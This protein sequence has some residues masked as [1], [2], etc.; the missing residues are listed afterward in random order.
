M[1]ARQYLTKIS[2][3]AIIK[4]Y[5]EWITQNSS[6]ELKGVPIL[7]PKEKSFGDYSIGIAMQIA[8]ERK[9]NPEQ[10]AEDLKEALS[11]DDEFFDYFDLAQVVA[12]GFINFYLSKQYL[13]KIGQEVLRRGSHFGDLNIGEKQ[14]IQVEFVSANPTGP[15]TIGNGRGGPYGDVLAKI[16]QKAGYQVRK[17]YYIN[18]YGNQILALGHSVLKDNEAKYTGEYIDKLHQEL[19]YY[20]GDAYKIGK[21][22]AKIILEKSIKPTLKKLNI[23]FDE[24]F[25]ETTLYKTKEV[26]KIIA[27]LKRKG[28]LYEKDGATWFKSTEFGDERDRVIIKSDGTKTYLAGDIAYHYY[29][30]KKQ[31]FN[32]VIDI[33][34][35]DHFGDVPGLRAGVEALGY[36]GKLEI[37]LLQFVTI[38][39]DG[40]PMK[41]S[42]RLGTAITLDDLLDE[43]PADVIRFFFLEK[44][45]DTHL[46]FDMNLAKEQSEKNPVYYIQY[47]YARINS[48]LSKNNGKLKTAKELSPLTKSKE[49][50]LLKQIS[51]FPEIIEDIAKDKQVQH[52]TQYV[53]DLAAT[54]HIFYNDCYVLVDDEP[55]RQAR[56]SLVKATQIV[57]KNTLDILG[58]SAPKK[59]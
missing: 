30:F 40:K 18:D 39:K 6:K 37:I 52:L 56:L 48:L 10:V 21:R 33:W 42:K 53:L 23:Q 16:F 11:K 26:D 22:A 17:A 13:W 7:K 46:N 9:Q 32:K 31:K 45:S 5:P 15:L 28:F 1:N 57:L 47:A 51:Y 4:L 27:L 12:P 8:K 20:N 14:K 3:E 55:L 43:L 24:W 41:M 19:S 50:D 38:M 25:S 35:A 49:L 34:G 59:M 2:R 36:Q 58:I 44:S 54:F 29:K